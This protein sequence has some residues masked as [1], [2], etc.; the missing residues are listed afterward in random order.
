[1]STDDQQTLAIQ[2]RAM[3]EYAARR[4]RTIP[5]V[6]DD[7]H[8]KSL[9]TTHSAEATQ[10]LDPHGA[11]GDLRPRT[12]SSGAQ[13]SLARS[14]TPAQRGRLKKVISYALGV[15]RAEK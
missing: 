12:K 10:G 9:S 6:R 4:G 11:V 14:S 2:N 13:Q 8:G 5:L 15:R 3:R 1:V 7:L